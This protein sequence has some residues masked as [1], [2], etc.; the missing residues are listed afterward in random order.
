LISSI[1]ANRNAKRAAIIHLLFNLA[2]AML[3]LPILW[4]LRTQ[5]A[6][7]FNGAI[8][9]P[10]W[11]I[12]VF[13]LIVTLSTAVLLLPFVKPIVALTHK[14]IRERPEQITME[15]VIGEEK[16]D[17]QEAAFQNFSDEF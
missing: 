11:Q 4:P 16:P 9:D 1:S 14:I 2:V 5:F 6:D 15:D 17:E 3:W 7:W 10:V 12:P 8:P 13:T